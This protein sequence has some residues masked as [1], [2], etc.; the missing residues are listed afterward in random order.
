MGGAH[1][2]SN[3][4]KKAQFAISGELLRDDLFPLLAD[5]LIHP[6]AVRVTRDGGNE[7]DFVAVRQPDT[8]ALR[9]KK[10]SYQITGE[11]QIPKS[12]PITSRCPRSTVLWMCSSPMRVD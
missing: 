11:F 12:P 9:L 4:Q 7:V 1:A 5:Q 10:G 6:A 3:R 8:L 2:C